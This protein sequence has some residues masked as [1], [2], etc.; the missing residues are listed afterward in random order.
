MTL[1]IKNKSIAAQSRTFEASD[2]DPN[3]ASYIDQ[4]CPVEKQIELK[5]GAQVMLAKNLNVDVGL[6]NG[7]R[8]VVIGFEAGMYGE[9]LCKYK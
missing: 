5:E 4:H 2:S 1:P 3:L 7:A 9:W 6:V 8:G